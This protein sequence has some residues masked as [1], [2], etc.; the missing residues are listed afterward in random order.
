M[1]ETLLAHSEQKLILIG[2]FSDI[3]IF[4]VLNGR[5]KAI[6]S[7]STPGIWSQAQFWASNLP[8]L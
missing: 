3:Y 7:L 8:A 4:V 5:P 6:N 1:L 2:I